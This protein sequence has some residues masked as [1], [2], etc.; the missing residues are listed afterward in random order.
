MTNEALIVVD[1][2]E[3]FRAR[4]LWRAVSDPDVIE[5]V[6][7]LV[8]GV[9]ARDGKVAWILHS[10]PGTRTAFDPARG[11]VRVVEELTVCDGEPIWTKTSYN[12]FSTTGL[13]QWLVANR[14]HELIVC[15]LRTEQCVETTT[16]VACDL[17]YSV[18]FAIDATATF[19]IP[20][21]DAPAG[22]S[23]EELLA[24]PRTLG[25]EDVKTRTVYALAGRFADVRTV[26]EIL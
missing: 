20:H 9:R 23:V 13:Q 15:G 8:D 25:S 18:T 21:P 4:P 19:P 24:D 3:S 22:L 7:T 14:I 11:F 6:K 2:Q 12:S 5:N 1:V 17:G 16:R 26:K 10:E